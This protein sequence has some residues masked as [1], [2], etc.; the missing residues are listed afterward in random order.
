MVDAPTAVL[1]EQGMIEDDVLHAA[2]IVRDLPD[3]DRVRTAAKVDIDSCEA[4]RA[5]QLLQRAVRGR[6]NRCL[7][8]CRRQCERQVTNDVA[9]TADFSAAQG[10][11]L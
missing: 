2:V 11:I 1:C 3:I 4:S 7:P 9:D 5:V 10:A 6:G 8:A